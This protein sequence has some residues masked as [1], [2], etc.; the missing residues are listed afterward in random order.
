MS[1]N[2]YPYKIFKRLF[3]YKNIKSTFEDQLSNK[4]ARGLDRTGITAFNK[5]KR[6]HFRIIYNKCKNGTYKFTPYIEKLHSKGRGKA[7]RIISIATIRDRIVL[8][9]LK[10][11]LHAVFPECVNRKLPNSYIRDIK[12]FYESFAIPQLCYFKCDIMG[13]Y[14]NIDRKILMEAV[15][16]RI[17]SKRIL[18]LIHLSVITPTVPLTYKRSERNNFRMQS[19]IPQGLATSNILANIYLSDFDTN[20]SSLGYKYFRYVDD[21]IVFTDEPNKNA[22]ESS[23]KEELGNLGL[24]LSHEKTFCNFASCQV[25]YLGYKIELPKVSIRD[26]N[27]DR[28]IIS[29]AAKFT[30]FKN[31]SDNYLK[32]HEWLTKDI[33]KQV[34]IEDLNEKITGAISNKRRYG[35][36]VYFIEINDMQLL[37][38]LDGIIQSF[39]VRLD[40]FGFCPPPQLKRLSTSFYKIKYDIGGGYIHNYELYDSVPKKLRYLSER[41]LLNPK[42]LYKKEEIEILFSRTKKRHLSK[43]DLD[44]GLVS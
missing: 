14:D 19:G 26:T 40:D 28:F 24:T 2:E 44:V 11:F 20:A 9:L 33:Q 15:K 16:R 42:K 27:I 23:I 32:K 38:K 7:P 18:L 5:V 6:E 36:L 43:L 8:S 3:S 4:A 30:S 25:D 12:E 29:I 34:F 22:V 35:W 10:E 21:I 39:F 37:H 41:G 31:N 1:A 13:F 17:K